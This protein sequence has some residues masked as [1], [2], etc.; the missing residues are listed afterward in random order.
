[1]VWWVNIYCTVG[2][3]GLQRNN[4]PHHSLHRGLQGNFCSSAWS[5][6]SSSIRSDL[7]VCRAVS[8]RYFHYFL[9]SAVMQR[10]FTPF[11]KC[12]HKDIPNITDWISFGQMAA[13]G[14]V[15][16]GSSFWHLLTDATLCS[17]PTFKTLS[18]KPNTFWHNPAPECL[19][20]SDLSWCM[21]C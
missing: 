9:S 1:M 18:H 8:L 11:M 6:S 7:A 19:V 13:S 15:Q 20:T 2:L 10:V 21:P 16:Y 5:T 4:L 3:H 12:Y 14:S 17:S